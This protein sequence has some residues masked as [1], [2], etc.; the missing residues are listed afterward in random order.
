MAVENGACRIGNR[1]LRV[2]SLSQHSVE[3]RDRAAAGRAVA[4]ALDQLRQ[5]GENRG[6]I[7]SCHRRFSNGQC[8]FALRHGVTRQRIHDQQNMLALITEMFGN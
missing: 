7:A 5:A 8:N 4:C 1:V 6:R 2:V 3:G